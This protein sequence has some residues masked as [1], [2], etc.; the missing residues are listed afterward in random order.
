MGAALPPIFFVR[1]EKRREFDG[2]TVHDLS[3]IERAALDGRETVR[4]IMEFTRLRQGTAPSA[5][6]LKAVMRDAV[7]ITRTRWK[8]EAERRDI[9]L[10]HASVLLSHGVRAINADGDAMGT[11]G[12]A[13]LVRRQRDGCG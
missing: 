3:V 13:D 5:V 4:R 11:G 8:T 7:E 10:D 9:D 6:D 1:R 2:P 12:P